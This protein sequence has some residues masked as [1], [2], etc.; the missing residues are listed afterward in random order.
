MTMTKLLMATMLPGN[1]LG[2]YAEYAGSGN[3]TLWHGDVME[4]R[5]VLTAAIPAWLQV[6]VDA[7]KVGGH[8]TEVPNPPPM[9][10]VWFEVNDKM[11]LVQFI[12]RSKAPV[13]EQDDNVFFIT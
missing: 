6:I 12:D 1:K 7:A 5:Y 2:R 13:S 9:R 4:S 8:I 11:E 10:V 3:Y